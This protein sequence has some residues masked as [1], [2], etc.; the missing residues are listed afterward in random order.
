MTSDEGRSSSTT[1]SFSGPK[2]CGA[3]GNME[4]DEPEGEGPESLPTSGHLTSPNFPA[5]YPL[6]LHERKTIEV[7][8]GNVIKIHFTDLDVERPYDYVDIIDGDGTFLAH[9]GLQYK[10]DEG[11]DGEGSGDGSGEGSG[12]VGERQERVI[13]SFTETV[14]VL[15]HTDD[16]VSLS[17]WRLEWSSFPASW[18]ELPTSGHLTSPNYPKPDYPNNYDSLQRIRVPEG[19]TIWMRFSDFVC[20]PRFDTVTITDKD[21]TRLGLFDG[22]INSDDDWVTKEMFSN[23]DMVEVQFHTDGGSHRMGWRLDWRM[24]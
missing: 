22:K 1:G 5:N 24:A 19:N 2:A 13:I 3:P 6:E 21:G 8:K 14:H 7:A 4:G 12:E 11:D 10:L 23:S 18:R 16:S 9:F 17:G 20:E 15:F